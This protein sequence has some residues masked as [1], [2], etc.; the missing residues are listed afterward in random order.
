MPHMHT[1]P[2]GTVMPNSKMPNA[3]SMKYPGRSNK[4]TSDRGH[5]PM[6]KQTATA[7]VVR[8]KGY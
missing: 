3:D 5:K 6:F 2:D 7:S 8:A 4:N 1:M